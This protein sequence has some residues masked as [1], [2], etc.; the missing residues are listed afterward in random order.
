M[1]DERDKPE[2]REPREPLERRGRGVSPGLGIG[3]AYV[4]DRR[5][6]NI[7]HTLIERDDV[8]EELKRFRAALRGAQD[9]LEAVKG[10]L[11]QGEHRQILKAQQMMLRD[12]GL[13]QRTETWIREELI[14]AEWAVSKTV[15]EIRAKLAEVGDEYFQARQYDVAFLGERLITTLGGEEK[16]AINPPAGA[17]IV[18]HDLSP[19]DTSQLSQAQV[20]GIIT[21]E[22]GTTSH[23]AIIAR[24]LRI[25]AVV[26]VADLLS[27]VDTG[28]LV[29]VD[30]VHGLAH[31]RPTP[32]QIAALEVE[33]ERYEAFELEIA[34]EHALPAQTDDGE[35]IRLRAN[36]ALDDE[37]EVARGF[38]AE[39][40]GLYRTEF[41]FMNRDEA[42][43]DEEHYRMAKALLQ[44]WAPHPVR[45][46]TF[47]L[48]SDKQC[49]SLDMGEAEHN[50][51]M[52]LRS[53]RLALRR[54]EQFL[55]QLRGLLRAGLHGPLQIMLPLVSG[56]EELA[57]GRA[58]IDE[59]RAQLRELGLPHADEVSVGV[60]IE[61]PSAA[62]TADLMARHVDFMSIG[63]NDLIQY[64]LAI[65]RDNDEV[66]YLYEPLHPAILRL[67]KTVCDAGDRHRVPVSLCGEMAADPRY[68]WVLVGLGLRELSMQASA[69]PV[70]K[71]IIRASTLDEM[72]ALAAAVLACDTAADAR[73]LVIQEMGERFPEHLQ[74]AAGV[75]IDIED[76]P[77]SS[78]GRVVRE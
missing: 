22:G 60:M 12:P 20:A 47:D 16:D 2:P 63:T 71:N 50:P 23:T 69:I 40:V 39:G 36:L 34:K 52:G 17:V 9:Q 67:I 54:P 64:T 11:P 7:P 78:V 58:A 75:D 42:P 13:I 49:R 53:M 68:T 65:D 66:N 3:P 77:I 74:H 21:E 35:N 28:D 10:R 25:P 31:V 24:A 51:A 15:D 6:V 59:A 44:R 33:V 19:A 26:G 4:V 72:E 45:V 48:G 76:E 46:R 73:R 56:L 37:N 57:A 38:G 27:A 5:E 61:V 18:A 41:M 14:G 8:E 1:I 43:S 55:A 30:G 29:I 62:I 70:V 32:E